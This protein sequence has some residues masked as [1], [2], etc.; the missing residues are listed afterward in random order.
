[1]VRDGINAAVSPTPAGT[2]PVVPAERL[3]DDILAYHDE[4]YGGWPKP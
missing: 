1:M 4:W 3:R 2:S